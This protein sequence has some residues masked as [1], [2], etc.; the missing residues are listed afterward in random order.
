MLPAADAAGQ[1]FVQQ[2]SPPDNSVILVVD[3]LIHGI[4]KNTDKVGMIPV[5]QTVTGIVDAIRANWDS[6]M[7]PPQSE[8]RG[9]YA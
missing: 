2:Q 3:N 9:A 8:N 5:L 7:H 4:D 1:R 6:F